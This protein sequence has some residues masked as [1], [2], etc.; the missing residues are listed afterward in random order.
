MGDRNGNERCGDVQMAVKMNDADGSVL[1]VDAAKE[2]ESDCV[3]AAE[4]DHAREGFAVFRG[5]FEVCVGCWT[6]GENA[7]VA[8]F[9][10]FDGVCVVV[11]FFLGGLVPLSTKNRS[12]MLPPLTSRRNSRSHR[13]VT[14][15]YHSRPTV[16]RIRLERNVES[17]AESK[18]S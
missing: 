4:G 17:T 7:V 5:A 18:F 14:A 10:L 15:I 2:R 6:A 12:L 9:D 16:E 11:S 1:A 13:N 3:I 8:F